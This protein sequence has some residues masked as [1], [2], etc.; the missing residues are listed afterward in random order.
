MRLTLAVITPAAVLTMLGLAFSAAVLL[1]TVAI[2][3][4]A[5][6]LLP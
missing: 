3:A 6:E 2:V 4:V 5:Y 1:V